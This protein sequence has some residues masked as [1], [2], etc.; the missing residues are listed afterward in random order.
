[1][2]LIEVMIAIVLLAFVVFGITAITDNSQA[3]KDRTIQTDRDNLQIETAMARLDTDFSQIWSPLYF[4]QKF[5]G[6][7]DP[8]TN[9]NIL[10]T[11]YLYERHPRLRLPNQ[12]G[13]PIPIMRSPEKTEFMFLSMANRRKL[14]NQKQSRFMWIRYYLGDMPKD[15]G[16]PNTGG[17]AAGVASAEGQTG[18]ALLRQIFPED[19]WSK[20]EFD[21]ENTRS[22]V[23]LA[24]VESLEFNFWNPT[25]KKWD[26]NIKSA[27]DGELISRGVRFLATWYDSRGLKRSTERWLRPLWPNWLPKDPAPG[28]TTAGTTTA[29]TTT[30]GA[31]TAGTTTAGVSAGV[32]GGFT[33]GGFPN[34]LTGSGFPGGFN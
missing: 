23:V 8:S 33:T 2:T 21:F 11:I 17:T 20:E 24:N 27:P 32:Q 31:T 28:S 30:A 1:M 19:V 6:S 9:P 18:K 14:Q 15:D 29:G 22:S 25:T 34:N 26:T 4:S 12:D 5:Q 10:E 16:A 7:F 3:T 13:L